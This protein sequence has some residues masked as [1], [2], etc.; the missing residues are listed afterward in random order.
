ML[1]FLVKKGQV[2]QSNF[3]DYPVTRIS[4]APE[5]HVHIVDS[6]APPGGIGEPG[7]PPVA[8][9]ITHAIYHASRTHIRD[10]PVN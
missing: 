6:D 1:A 10:L 7:L 3:H 4:Q 2:Q 9:R 8:P 5:L